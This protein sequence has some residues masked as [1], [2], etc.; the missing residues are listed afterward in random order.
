MVTQ[1]NLNHCKASQDILTKTIIDEGADIIL[2]SELYLE[3]DN[4]TR[5]SDKTKPQLA[6]Q[7]GSI[8]FRKL[9]DERKDSRGQR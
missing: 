4:P 3:L 2:I 9:M 1:I 5:V 7:E 8:P 6:G